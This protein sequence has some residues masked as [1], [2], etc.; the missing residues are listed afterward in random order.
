MQCENLSMLI[1]FKDLKMN[2][3]MKDRLRETLR[4]LKTG[5]TN[6]KDTNNDVIQLDDVLNQIR[7]MD[8]HAPRNVLHAR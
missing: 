1:F 5:T 2:C 3:S 8:A 4:E 6:E 7:S